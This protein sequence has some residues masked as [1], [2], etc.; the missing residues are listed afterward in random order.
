MHYEIAAGLYGK[1]KAVTADG[2]K[3]EGEFVV[4]VS[5]KPPK[6]HVTDSGKVETVN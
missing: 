6:T 3:V 4:T 2:G 5:D 1:A